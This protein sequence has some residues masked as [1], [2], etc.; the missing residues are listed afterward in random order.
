MTTRRVDVVDDHHGTAI[1]DPYRWLEDGDDPEVRDWVAGQ[2]ART[3]AALD[4]VPARAVWLDRLVALMGEPVAM[5]AQV[6]GDLVVLLERERDAQQARLAV[7]RLDRPGDAPIV[8]ADPAA[9]TDDAA[10]AVDW[11]FASPDGALVAY[12]VSEG[13]TEDSVLRIA[14]T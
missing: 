4:A 13:G 6:R 14:G 1:A 10:A 8:L 9:A 11:F 3:R 2:N 12:G 7:R 5:G